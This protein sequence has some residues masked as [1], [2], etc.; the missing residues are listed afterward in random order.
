MWGERVAWGSSEQLWNCSPE[1]L[2]PPW[3]MRQEKKNGLLKDPRVCLLFST[4]GTCCCVFY[5]LFR[6]NK[7]KA[8]WDSSLG[9]CLGLWQKPS[10]LALLCLLGQD[11]IRNSHLLPGLHFLEWLWTSESM[12]W[13]LVTY[14]LSYSVVYY[15]VSELSCIC[16][17]LPEKSFVRA[18]KKLT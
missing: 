13:H 1:Q 18:L 6:G 14:L 10:L 16:L 9:L 2:L 17:L 3:I 12:A 15:A 11:D 8:G 5:L 4:E 7:G